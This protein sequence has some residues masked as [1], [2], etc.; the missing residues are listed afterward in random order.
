MGDRIGAPRGVRAILDPKLGPWILFAAAALI[1]FLRPGGSSLWTLEGRTAVICRERMRTGDYFHPYL[2][3]DEYYAKPL[4]PYWMV[5]GAA[6]MTGSLDE[7]AMRLP[8]IVAALLAVF[9]T[10]RI[11]HRLFG[12]SAGIAAG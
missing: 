1:L 4:L 2:F 11:G 9:A 8:G 6:R 3:D 7:V 10:W 5:I 12:P